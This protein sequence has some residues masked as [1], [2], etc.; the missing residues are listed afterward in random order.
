MLYVTFFILCMPNELDIIGYVNKHFYREFTF[1][2]RVR[3]RVTVR[4]RVRVRV[5][6]TV[7]VR[8]RVRLLLRESAPLVSLR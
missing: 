1:R 3:V 7:T 6:V 4:V 5:R 8:V 2:V